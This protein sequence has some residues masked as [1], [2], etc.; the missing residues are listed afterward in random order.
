[1]QDLVAKGVLAQAIE[2]G[3]RLAAA[4]ARAST[5]DGKASLALRIE[6]DQRLVPEDRA[7]HAGLL[8]RELLGGGQAVEPR[9][10]HA[11]QRGRHLGREQLARR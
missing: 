3:V 8:Q 1:M 7:D 10:Q 6:R 5:S 9:L 11:R 2:R 4:R